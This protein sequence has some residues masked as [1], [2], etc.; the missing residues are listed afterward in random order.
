M[1]NAYTPAFPAEDGVDGLNKREYIAIAL[2]AGMC[3]R[4]SHPDGTPAQLAT[5]AV[6][7]ADALLEALGHAP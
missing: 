3:A 1:N 2:M 5:A 4:E 6:G 7:A